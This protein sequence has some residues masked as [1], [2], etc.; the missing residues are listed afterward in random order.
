VHGRLY[1]PAV[2]PLALRAVAELKEHL[3]VPIIAGGGVYGH[4]QAAALLRAGAAVVQ[5][6]GVMWTTPERVLSPE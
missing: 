5:L 4:E 3:G 1:G 2:F 6:D